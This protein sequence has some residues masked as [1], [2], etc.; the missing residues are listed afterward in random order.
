MDPLTQRTSLDSRTT[1]KNTNSIVSQADPTSL[2]HL[3][4]ASEDYFT[5]ISI[6]TL[7][8]VISDLSLSTYHPACVRA[9]L[10]ILRV[11]CVD[12]QKLR[13]Y[14]GLL[15]PALL[16]T[17][18]QSERGGSRLL[19]FLSDLVTVA[20]REIEPSLQS[21]FG[22]VA[23]YWDSE[24]YPDVLL[25]VERVSLMAPDSF[26]IH[27]PDLIPL[28]LR[29]LAHLKNEKDGMAKRTLETVVIIGRSLGEY[30]HLVAPAI[31]AV[32]ESSERSLEVRLQAM[33]TLGHLCRQ[34]S[35]RE[36]ASRIVHPLS[37]LLQQR[38]PEAKELKETAL[39]ILCYLM[40]Q[41]GSDYAIF[42]PVVK[43]ILVRHGIEHSEYE[44]LVTRLLKQQ[45][46]REIDLP[47]LN[48]GTGFSAPGGTTYCLS[49]CV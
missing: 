25:F 16:S 46:I 43:R 30:L 48:F 36:Y 10:E 12:D 28:L 49:F 38:E 1:F 21:L 32:F 26:K 22:I 20:R 17:L 5:D 13:R 34:L 19:P 9:V 8:R 45:P 44:N 7:T 3:Y 4:S 33:Q 39:K 31:V 29:S 35:F 23:M 6:T 24:V 14:L 40:F 15:L 41:L 42:I 47:R 37:R 2:I 11:C 18:Q 27:I